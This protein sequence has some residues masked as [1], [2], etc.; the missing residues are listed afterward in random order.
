MAKRYQRGNPNPNIKKKRQNNGQKKKY[1]RTNN[2]LQKIHIKLK[3][4]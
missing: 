3:I 2:D 4:E 1:K